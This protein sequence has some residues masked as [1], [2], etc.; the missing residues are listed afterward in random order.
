MTPRRG[1]EPQDLEV[2]RLL[3]FVDRGAPW[4]RRLWG[5]GTVLGIREVA[6]Y[7]QLQREGGLRVDGLNF[8][9]NTMLR[10]VG[11]DPACTPFSM[12][13]EECLGKGRDLKDKN[14]LSPDVEEQLCHLA[15][16]IEESYIRSWRDAIRGGPSDRPG[17]E[18][19]TR[20]IAGHF[21]DAG[22]SFEHIGGWLTAMVSTNASVTLE[23][24]LE[25]G[26]RM[27]T[28]SPT[29]QF[30]V[31]VPVSV[32]VVPAP[33]RENVD[34]MSASDAAAWIRA[35][36]VDGPFPRYDGAFVF[37]I[38]ARDPWSA[39]EEAHDVVERFA[40]R[41]RV[42]R[43]GSGTLSHKGVAYIDGKTRQYVMGQESRRLDI[44]ALD[45][46]GAIY[47]S[48]SGVADRID[49]ALE[50]ASYLGTGRPGPAI[51]GGWAAIEGLLLRSRESKHL[52]ADR[53]ATIT[54]CSI[55]RA[56]LTPLA[57]AHAKCGRDDL[58]MSLNSIHGE[59]K[60]YEM[61]LLTELHLGSGKTLTLDHRADE[62]AEQRILGLLRNPSD[63]VR[64]IETYMRE[65]FRRLYNQRNLL[66]HSAS[67][68]SI[69]LPATLR[70]SPP[71]VGAG[72][73][74]IVHSLLEPGI[75]R[76]PLSLA[77]RANSEL[78]L[79]GTSARANLVDLLGR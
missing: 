18:R 22:L 60:N 34:W 71:L 4:H 50:L 5:V 9:S 75:R 26:D 42:G 73:D 24:V 14:F 61:A 69:A 40:S 45:R 3:E 11:L 17:I 30:R 47:I 64:R 56:E 51:T 72:L 48:E 13:L 49:D 27:L 37:E 62:A 55:G 15:D 33:L 76:D 63:D 7:S 43:P 32:P 57:W 8:V 70:T 58:A 67:F 25:D 12:A 10:E 16:R 68:R 20:S 53:L 66:M 1:P 31:I 2:A 6:E 52:A 46:Q 39:V 21:L 38:E 23:D 41:V 29:R 65:S 79:L 77:A 19:A 44:H 54:A 35:H 74:R 78:D 28:D 59:G 36:G